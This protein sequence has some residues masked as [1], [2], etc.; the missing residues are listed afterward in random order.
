MANDMMHLQGLLATDD[1]RGPTGDRHVMPFTFRADPLHRP[2]PGN[3][4]RF[5]CGRKPLFLHCLPGNTM[6][7]V[8]NVIA[9]AVLLACLCAPAFA[10]EGNSE[11]AAMTGKIGY[12]HAPGDDE[13]SMSGPVTPMAE[14]DYTFVAG[15]AFSPRNSTTSVTYYSGG[16]IHAS[17]LVTTDLQLPGG[18]QIIGFRTYYYD[19]GDSGNI[20]GWI[21]SYD[22]AGTTTDL[23]LGHSTIETGYASEYFAFP[24]SY[25]V[26]NHNVALTL[27]ART[28]GTATQFCGMRVFYDQP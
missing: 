17:D 15:S 21:T 4:L 9:A 28:T 13:M 20:S 5:P 3:S 26:D 18:T 11:G 16:C 22:G 6:S 24:T 23:L 27:I 2:D 1:S 10:A 12:Y 14:T 25:L 8:H 7:P 19:N